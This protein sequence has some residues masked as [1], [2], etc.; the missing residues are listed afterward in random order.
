[1]RVR[2]RVLTLDFLDSP[3]IS[4]GAAQVSLRY[5]RRLNSL[6]RPA[7]LPTAGRWGPRGIRSARPAGGG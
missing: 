6:R 4:V 5:Q 1:M 3:C 2:L 7:F